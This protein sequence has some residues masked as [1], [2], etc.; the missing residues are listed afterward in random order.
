[1]KTLLRPLPALL[2][3]LQLAGLASPAMAQAQAKPASASGL[4]LSGFDPQ[5]RPQDDLYRA[6]NGR[7]LR[8][9]AI[10]ADRVEVHGVDMPAVVDGR[11]RAI[12]QALAARQHPAGS[13]EQKIGDYYRSY[14]DTAAIERAGLAPIKP[15]LAEIDAIRSPA[16]LARWQGRAQGQ[17]Q[18]PIWFWGGFA[19]FM[20]PG[21]NRVMAWQGGL[22]LPD[23]DY[24]LKL[25]EPA[26]AKARSAYL[27]Y[28]SRLATLAGDRDAARTAQRVLALETRLAAVHVPLSEA[29]DPS[30]MVNPLTPAEL[31]AQAP[32]FDWPT[33]FEAAQL[34]AGDKVNV[35]QLGTAIATARLFAELPLADW[36]AYFRLRS[37]DANAQ[38]LPKAFRQAHFAFHG[39]AMGGATAERAREQRAL[40]Q[41]SE[42]LSEALAQQYVARHFPPAHKQRV[43]QIYEQV[44]AAY[45]ELMAANSWM[46][47]ATRA[48][49]LDKL[50][51]Y[52]AKIGHPDQWRDYAALQVRAGDALGNQQRAQRFDWAVKA[53]AAGKPMDRQAW[54]MSPLVVNAFYD[55]MGNEINLTAAILQAPL[56]DM[57]ADDA[58]NFGGIG[59]QIG[60]EISH[61]FDS[62]GAQFDGQGAMRNWWTDED[63][64]TFA[65]KSAQLIA[66]F[67]AFEALPG[68]HVNGELTLPEN[69]A[70]LLG[71]QI[72]YKAYQ[73]SLGGKP[74][75]V[76]DGFSGE[77][78]FFMSFA[79]SWR[80]KRSEQRTLQ[81]LSSDPHAPNE[82]RANAPAMNLDAFHEA[83]KTAPGDALFKPATSR[84]QLW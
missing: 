14:L 1:M 55:P 69:M 79:Q 82:F 70:D 46:A 13:V 54:A 8:N 15:L 74:A 24:Y 30:K 66:Q 29:R 7:W 27:A 75:P 64:K 78:R 35:T 81:L 20:D 2:L 33:F 36:K 23:R 57:A 56:F 26:F 60:H 80:V 63:R 84:I 67:N 41:V 28:L 9:T 10:P 42:A 61:G 83:F 43:Q 50:D 18:T 77:Q 51:R 52:K 59:A 71:L 45:R 31:L 65:D 44:L 16:E 48:A 4:D 37:L 58:A 21:L 53:A 32:G 22:G 38:V 34:S 40:E 73:R 47:P 19:D 3:A 68:K 5:V 11:V 12:L 72:A 76:I 6:V 62:M 17:L 49:A 25:D 39:A